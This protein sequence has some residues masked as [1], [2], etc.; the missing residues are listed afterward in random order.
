MLP[1]QSD[2]VLSV[3]FTGTPLWEHA[4]N[5]DT[6]LRALCDLEDKGWVQLIKVGGPWSWQVTTPG[7]DR[8][9]QIRKED[10]RAEQ[11]K[12]KDLRHTM[13]QAFD[14]K[15]RANPSVKGS[16]PLDVKEF[17]EA[18]GTDLN[19]YLLQANRLLDQGLLELHPFDQSTIAKGHADITEMGRRQLDAPPPGA[20]PTREIAD[21]YREIAHL[22][23]QVEILS[24]NP[25]GLIRDQQLRER[26]SHLLA[27]DTQLG[28]AVREAFVVLEDRIRTKGEHPQSVVGVDLMTVAFNKATGH[29]ILSDLDPE[30]DG[31]HLTFRG[32]TMWVRNAFGHRIMD[33]T[34][35]GDAIR[36][37]AF[38]DYLLQEVGRARRRP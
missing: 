33:A 12:E 15:W 36:I 23:R 9:A 7:L 10:E 18:N 16:L 27:N 2:H 20:A 34:T 19:A 24:T 29:L 13:L 8:A 32:L 5:R 22:R 6:L 4:T 3:A 21:L 17:C 14:T 38:V 25:E 26:V 11:T 30:Q 35:A 37:I 1:Q 28:T 31:A